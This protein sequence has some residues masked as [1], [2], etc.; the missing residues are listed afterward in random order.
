M[1]KPSSVE[2]NRGKKRKQGNILLLP[3][4][5]GS[6]KIF[7]TLPI[8]NATKIRANEDHSFGH[9]KKQGNINSKE[10]AKYL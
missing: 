8:N 5:L 10:G 3:L 2:H 1:L 6:R 9:I 4:G 7:Q